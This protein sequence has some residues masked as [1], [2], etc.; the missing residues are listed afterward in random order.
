[1]FGEFANP[2]GRVMSYDDSIHWRVRAEEMRALAEAMTGGISKHVMHRIAEDYERFAR[3]VE[4]R[5]NRF[6]AIPPVPP[7]EVRRFAPCKDSGSA[8]PG[9]IDLELPSFLKR[10]P[11][12]A[13]ELEASP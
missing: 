1:M 2:G 12:T 5:P 9:S 13:A 10:G 6:L 11:A 8:P 3:M 7:A 4:E